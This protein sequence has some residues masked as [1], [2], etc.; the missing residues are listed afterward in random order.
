MAS[1]VIEATSTEVPVKQGSQV[2]ETRPVTS[3]DKVSGSSEGP[4]T[5]KT[6]NVPS[7][8]PSPPPKAAPGSGSDTILVATLVMIG[9]ALIKDVHEG[10]PSV[11]PVVTGMI[12]GGV[13]LIM[14]EFAPTLAKG[15]AVTGMVGSL[16]T[17]GAALM[18]VSNAITNPANSA[19]K[20]AA[21]GGHM[22]GVM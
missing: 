22:T 7:P 2:A 13:L 18:S 9:A 15:L 1:R 14:G 8:A 3:V 21:T 17:N 19:P 6:K 11:R 20:T 10:K 5:P 16:I 12:L 4:S